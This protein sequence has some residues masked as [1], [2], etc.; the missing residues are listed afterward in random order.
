MELTTKADV[1]SFGVVLWELV[2]PK[3]DLLVAWVST[4][5][6]TAEHSTAQCHRAMLSNLTLYQ[7]DS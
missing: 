6:Q 2:S 1:Y 3:Q 5:A 7:L 4:N